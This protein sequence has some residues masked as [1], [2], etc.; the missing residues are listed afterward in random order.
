MALSDIQIA[1][2]ATLKPVLPMA[3][4]RLGIPASALE[5]YGHY[6][7]K[8]D[9]ELAGPARPGRDGKLVLVTAIS[10]TPA[11][12]GKTTTTVG[13]GDAL[14]RIGKRASLRCASPRW[15]RCSA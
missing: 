15:G 13:L 2:A 10:P 8:I 1:Q 9:L 12:E 11:G 14:N 5:P 6:K 7:A 4:D 3:Q